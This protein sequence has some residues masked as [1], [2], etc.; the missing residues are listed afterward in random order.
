MVK[1]HVRFG[2]LTTFRLTW[3]VEKYIKDPKTPGNHT[4]EFRI[5]TPI[6]Y[7]MFAKAL[8]Y[9]SLRAYQAHV[10][11]VAHDDDDDDDDDHSGYLVDNSDHSNNAGKNTDNDAPKS[12]SP[13][14]PPA[15]RT[16]YQTKKQFD[17]RNTTYQAALDSFNMET[18]FPCDQ[19]AIRFPDHDILLGEGASGQ[20]ILGYVRRIDEKEWH[21]AA[22][23]SIEIPKDWKCLLPGMKM[24]A[25]VL[26]YLNGIGVSCAPKLLYAGLYLNAYYLLATE[27]VRDGKHAKSLSELDEKQAACFNRARYE[28]HMAGVY[29]NDLRSPNVLFSAS[30]RCTIIDYGSAKFIVKSQCLKPL[31]ATRL[32]FAE[33]ED[34]EGD[35]EAELVAVDLSTNEAIE[36]NT[37]NNTDDSSS[38][39]IGGSRSGSVELSDGS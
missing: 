13:P 37:S 20:V 11:H 12:L 27:Y 35:F 32:D 5:S 4:Y 23:K 24:E 33:P 17:E 19:Y 36:G 15:K 1:N 18:S 10:A 6:K 22:V 2:T 14:E 29:H 31:H 9:A 25:R 26:A 21:E 34:E 8:I 16:R 28:M 7:K 30:S 39:S 3:I 38:G